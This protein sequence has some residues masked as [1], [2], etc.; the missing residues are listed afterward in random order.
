MSSEV[1]SPTRP[2]YWSVRREVWENRS[3]YIA[4][5]IVAAVVLFGSFISTMAMSR[6]VRVASDLAPSKQNAA[7]VT[8]I[9]MA[10]APIMLATIL[11]GFFYS[12]DALYGERRDRS[13][14]L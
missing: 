14:L 2:F 10:P 7:I 1:M 6:N 12:Y 5:L 13:I 11:I 3:V 8:P 4:P 9:N